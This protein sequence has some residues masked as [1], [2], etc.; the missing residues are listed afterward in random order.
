MRIEPGVYVRGPKNL[1]WGPGLVL[2]LPDPDTVAVFFAAGGRRIL[3]QPIANLW[4]VKDAKNPH[5][6]LE[7]AARSDWSAWQRAHHHVYAIELKPAVL[8]IRAFV[9]ANLNHDPSK[10]CLYVGMTGIRP[11]ERLQNHL[12]GH[13]AAGFVRRYGLGLRPELYEHFN[14]MP[15]AVA[16]AMEAELAADLRRK[17]YAVWQK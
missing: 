12:N 14:P 2:A 11:Q 9:D 4:I 10:P 3:K 15:Y 1:E 17:G 6:V 16:K 5:P 8:A 7:I 13:K